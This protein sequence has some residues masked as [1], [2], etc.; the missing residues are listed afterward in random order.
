MQ[1]FREDKA[2]LNHTNTSYLF[3]ETSAAEEKDPEIHHFQS[4]TV[5]WSYYAVL[6]EGP[7]Q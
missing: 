6:A 5:L 3:R 2:E 4:F 7:A 1:T